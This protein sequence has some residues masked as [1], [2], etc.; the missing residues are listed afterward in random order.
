VIAE[1]VEEDGL[2]QRIELG[3]CAAALGP[4]RLRP[5][6]HLRNPPLL[7]QRGKGDLQFADVFPVDLLERGALRL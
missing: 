6:Q 7:T 2:G 4:Q 3:E 1:E 5:V